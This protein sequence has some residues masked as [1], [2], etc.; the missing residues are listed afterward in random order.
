MPISVIAIIASVVLAVGAHSEQSI[1]FGADQAPVIRRH[2]SIHHSGFKRQEQETSIHHDPAGA[3]GRGDLVAVLVSR[4]LGA[5]GR[6][7]NHRSKKWPLFAARRCGRSLH[8]QGV[9]DCGFG[10]EI[11]DDGCGGC[12]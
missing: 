9:A 12:R 5:E 3:A 1:N 7:G 4:Y 2:S 10:K 11:S 6:I 8:D